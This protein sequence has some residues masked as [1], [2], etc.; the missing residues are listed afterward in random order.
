MKSF[1]ICIILI[2][3]SFLTWGQDVQEA[4]VYRINGE[5]ILVIGDA[6]KYSQ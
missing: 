6:Q 3:S 2:L 1:V 4:V 5:E